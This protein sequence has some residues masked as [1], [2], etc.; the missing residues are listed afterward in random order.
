MTFPNGGQRDEYNPNR[1]VHRGRYLGGADPRQGAGTD[2]FS[3]ARLGMADG[4]EVSVPFI[5]RPDNI[6]TAFGD[7]EVVM[8]Q[9]GFNGSWQMNAAKH[10]PG[11]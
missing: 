1:Q 7:R 11:A 8:D 9:E 10:Y 4:S 5:H 2:T 6:R 3:T